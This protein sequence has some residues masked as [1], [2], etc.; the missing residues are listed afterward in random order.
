MGCRPDGHLY[1]NR[2]NLFWLRWVSV[3][4]RPDGHL[5]KKYLGSMIYFMVSVGCRPD[6]HLY[7]ALQTLDGP[8]N[9]FSGLSPGWSLVL[10]DLCDFLHHCRFQ[11]AVARMVTCT[12]T[13]GAMVQNITFQWAVARM[14]TCTGRTEE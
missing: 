6:V 7:V 9:C 5:Y 10:F 1:F 12:G 11:W 2:I 8:I 13:D 14:V 3:G 4:C